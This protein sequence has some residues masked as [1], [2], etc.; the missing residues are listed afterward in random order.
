MDVEEFTATRC[1]RGDAVIMRCSQKLSLHQ[2]QLLRDQ[3]EDLQER[4]GLTFV[5]IDSNFTVELVRAAE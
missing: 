1:S 4:T 5:F 3:F 2:M